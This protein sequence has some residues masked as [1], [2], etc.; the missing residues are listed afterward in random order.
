[1]TNPGETADVICTQFL[2]NVTVATRTVAFPRWATE[3]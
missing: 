3:G 1:M 2:K